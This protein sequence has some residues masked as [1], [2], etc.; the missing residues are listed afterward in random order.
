MKNVSIK[1][2][3]KKRFTKFKKATNFIYWT[4]IL[5]IVGFFMCLFRGDSTIDIG[6]ALNVL[7]HYLIMNL[8][9]DYALKFSLSFLFCLLLSLVFLLLSIPTRK[10][11]L[12]P[13]ILCFSLYLI[14]FIFIFIMPEVYYY[15]FN[16]KLI[17][18]F[19]HVIVTG[20]FIYLLYSYFKI[21]KLSKIN[22]ANKK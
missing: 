3:I 22:S 4:S 5:N 7:S 1:N 18:I 9:I 13:L 11:K 12:I 16:S 20:Y 6:Y 15:N 14:D 21:V 2:D 19:V 10:G 17:N 8:T